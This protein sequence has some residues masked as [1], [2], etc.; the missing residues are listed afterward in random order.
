MRDRVQNLPHQEVITKDGVTCRVDAAIQY[1]VINAEKAVLGVCKPGH[2]VSDRAQVSLR[3]VLGE[4]SVDD[5]LH[6]RGKLSSTIK[7]RLL[8]LE[9]EWGIAIDMIQIKD[10]SF[11]ESMTRAMAKEAEAERTAKSK[12]IHAK[13]DI[14]TAEQYEKAAAIY[15]EN[16]IT[17]KLREL[18]LWQ[19]VAKEKGTTLFIVPSDSLNALRTKKE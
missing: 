12:V 13:A 19:S 16:P 9:N 3:E 7:D 18:H 6:Q 14:V 11:D 4:N 5:I 15:N 2:A 1:K 17:M 8:H 10:L